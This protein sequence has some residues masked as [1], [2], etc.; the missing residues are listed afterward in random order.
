[1]CSCIPLV[2][3]AWHNCTSAF[4]TKMMSRCDELVPHTEPDS[5]CEMYWKAQVFQTVLP[6]LLSLSINMSRW[7]GQ[8]LYIHTDRQTDSQTLIESTFHDLELYI[9][10]KIYYKFNSP[11]IYAVN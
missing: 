8:E 2:P 5:S 10:S 6:S 3:H 4:V 9:Q 7:S 11:T 1:M